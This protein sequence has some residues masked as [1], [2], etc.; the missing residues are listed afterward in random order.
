MRGKG[1]K[2]ITFI[3]IWFVLLFLISSIAIVALRTSRSE[4][5]ITNVSQKNG[6]HFSVHWMGFAPADYNNSYPDYYVCINNV[7]GDWL[8]MSIALQIKNQEAN[9]FY[10]LIDQYQTPPANWAISQYQIG[11]IAV[12][13]TNNFVYTN[14]SRAKPASIPS[15][16]LN[17]SVN[18]VVKAY[19]DSSYTDFYS[20]DNFTVSYHFIDRTSGW[21]QIAYDNFE[22]GTQDWSLSGGS[23]YKWIGL[24]TVYYR[25]FQHSLQIRDTGSYGYFVIGY[26]KTFNT[27]SNC[28]LLF[29][30]RS[31]KWDDFAIQYNGT[32]YFRP[33]ASLAANT[34]YQFA[35]PIPSGTVQVNIL[36]AGWLD[37][38]Y[39]DDVYLIAR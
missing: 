4:I 37:S 11:L 5:D 13:G 25:S 34:W 1:M 29:S 26:L 27:T 32:S 35:V 24:T 30:M 2:L 12:D 8:N 31:A 9:G 10:F 7:K 20:Q 28:V 15:G 19:R 18:L 22:N 23:A 36:V 6:K 17:E 33:D 14:I 3:S 38:A 39:M 16:I 21:N